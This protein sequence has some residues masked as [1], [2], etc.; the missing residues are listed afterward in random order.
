M[1]QSEYSA[2]LSTFIRLPVVIKTFVL[3][4]LKW[5]I[6]TGFTVQSN[7]VNSMF[8]GLDVVFRTI[9]NSNYKEVHIKQCNNKYFFSIEKYV[10]FTHP[11][12][13]YMLLD[14]Y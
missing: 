9:S 3:T 14:S 2:I 6:Y 7:L 8:S 11:N 10:S 5:L 1:L 13:T 4:I 12:L